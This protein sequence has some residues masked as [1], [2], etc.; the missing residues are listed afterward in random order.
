MRWGQAMK[1]GQVST[2]KRKCVLQERGQTGKSFE[3]LGD[4]G[5]VRK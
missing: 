4:L 1:F 2:I 3:A 5:E